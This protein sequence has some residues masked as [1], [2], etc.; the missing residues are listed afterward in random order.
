MPAVKYCAVAEKQL[1]DR[2]FYRPT[3]PQ[4]NIDSKVRQRLIALLLHLR[5]R[6][7]ISPSELRAS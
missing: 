1:A 6:N 5:A 2:R 7:F 4:E 3:T